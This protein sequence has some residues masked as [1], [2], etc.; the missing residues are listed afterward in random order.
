M[1]RNILHGRW[2]DHRHEGYRDHLGSAGQ[3]PA[4][5][6]GGRPSPAGFWRKLLAFG[7][8]GYLV[9]VGYMDP[10][11][12]AT[13]LAGGSAFGYALLSVVLLSSMM[14]MLLQYLSAKLGIATGRDL[15]QLC[16]EHF[17]LR[18]SV[19]LWALCELAIIACDLAELLGTAIAL[20]LLFGEI[21]RAHV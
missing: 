9:A 4:P 2:K 3:L 7:G 17:S 18:V 6:D 1:I 14:A 11:N 19:T 12:W 21:G 10:G 20:K 15:A 16:R 5:R 8:P 13:D